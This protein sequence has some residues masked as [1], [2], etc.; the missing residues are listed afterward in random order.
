MLH[1][2]YDRE[3]VKQVYRNVNYLINEFQKYID[4]EPHGLVKNYFQAELDEFI[5]DRNNSEYPD[6][7]TMSDD[8]FELIYEKVGEK[9]FNN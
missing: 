1:S 4:K 7:V 5:N 9:Y 2:E 6:E 8:L 3:T